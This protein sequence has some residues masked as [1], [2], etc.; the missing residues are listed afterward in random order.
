MFISI[1]KFTNGKCVG[2]AAALESFYWLNQAS[3]PL[4]S[5]TLSFSHSSSSLSSYITCGTNVVLEKFSD[6]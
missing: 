2:K 3:D 1:Q 4:S 5:F 6:S